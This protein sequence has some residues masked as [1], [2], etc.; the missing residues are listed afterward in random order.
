[1]IYLPQSSRSNCLGADCTAGI[2]AAL[3]MIEAEV[4][5]SY[6]FHRNEEIGGLGS[7][8]IANIQADWISRYSHVV[9]LDRRGTN[10]IITHQVGERT[11]S[12][13]FAGELADAL[14]MAH[15]PAIG[16]FTD[17]A[18]YAHLVPE[19]TN[20]SVGYYNE[21]TPDE[22]LDTLY[23]ESLITKLCDVDWNSLGV[24]RYPR[25][26]SDL[27]DEQAIDQEITPYD[28]PQRPR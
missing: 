20:I 27:Y 25:D 4:P 5:V 15:K 23:L 7:R 8:W 16:I 24:Y 11:A 3:R 12:D 18:N 26:T 9:S 28:Y 10:D 2:Y 13:A 21:H 6:M 1:M 17:S 14:D 19:C 22:H